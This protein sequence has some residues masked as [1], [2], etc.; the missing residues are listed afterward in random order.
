[1]RYSYKRVH[2][3]KQIETYE[4]QNNESDDLCY[5]VNSHRHE[6]ANEQH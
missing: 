3:I 4:S 5:D 6:F 1:M 2:E